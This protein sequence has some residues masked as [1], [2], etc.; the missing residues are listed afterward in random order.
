[1]N[2]PYSVNI[3]NPSSETSEEKHRNFISV[4]CCQLF[5]IIPRFLWNS[6]LIY[7]V[8][9]IF[10]MGWMFNITKILEKKAKFYGYMVRIRENASTWTRRQGCVVQYQGDISIRFTQYKQYQNLS[11]WISMENCTNLTTHVFISIILHCISCLYNLT[12]TLL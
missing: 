12:I 8:L 9:Y 4:L 5:H 7:L 10:V 2:M 6:I 3:K 11:H 1:M